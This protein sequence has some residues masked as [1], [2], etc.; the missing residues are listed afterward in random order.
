MITGPAGAVAAAAADR[1]RQL[2][3]IARTGIARMRRR[4]GRGRFA[5]RRHRRLADPTADRAAVR[6]RVGAFLHQPDGDPGLGARIGQLERRPGPMPAKRL[7]PSAARA[8]A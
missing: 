5:Q 3:A 7:R 1:R 8:R 6:R 2:G 4:P